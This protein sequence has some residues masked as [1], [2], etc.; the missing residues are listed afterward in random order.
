VV[1]SSTLDGP[2]TVAVQPPASLNGILATLTKG[3]QVKTLDHVG[4]YV[5]QSVTNGIFPTIYVSTTPAELIMTRGAPS[6]EP[7]AGTSL[8]DVANTDDNLIVDPTTGL[9]YVLISGAGSRHLC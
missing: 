8:L 1:Q 6:Y 5:D 4:H 7:I 2:W 3:G 9:T